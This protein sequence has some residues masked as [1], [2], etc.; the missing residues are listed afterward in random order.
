M[1]KGSTGPPTWNGH[2][3]ENAWLPPPDKMLALAA[4]T[5]GAWARV[6]PVERQTP[7]RKGDWGSGYAAR[8]IGSE[9]GDA[10]RKQMQDML[11]AYGMPVAEAAVRIIEGIV[12][13]RFW[14]STHPELLAKSASQRA[15][16][17]ST[18]ADPA[19]P[20]Q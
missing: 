16:R 3:G 1:L 5:I 14:V 18:L 9:A 17:L 11:D 10:H 4:E 6:A 15:Q 7:L 19:V 8:G 13:G 2:R 20:A 12:S